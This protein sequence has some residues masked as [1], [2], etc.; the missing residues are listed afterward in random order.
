MQ[1]TALPVIAICFGILIAHELAGL[2]GIAMAAMAMLLESYDYI[3]F[4]HVRR[5]RHAAA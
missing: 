5:N 3:R 4:R 2:Y 1:A